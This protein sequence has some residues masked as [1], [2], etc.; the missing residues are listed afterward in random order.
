MKGSG[1][2]LLQE[3]C[4]RVVA[5]LLDPIPSYRYP[6]SRVL[7]STWCRSIELSKSIRE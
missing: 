2:D 7:R 6:A 4:R 3:Y 1:T 5:A